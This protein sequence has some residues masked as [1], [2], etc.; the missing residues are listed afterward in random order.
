MLSKCERQPPNSSPNYGQNDT[1]EMWIRKQEPSWV[2]FVLGAVPLTPGSSLHYHQSH[3]GTLPRNSND[4]SASQHLVVFY[5]TESSW[6]QTES[7][8]ARSRT[9]HNH[10]VCRPTKCKCMQMYWQSWPGPQAFAKRLSLLQKVGE[11][12]LPGPQR[13]KEEAGGL[14]KQ[15][16][17]GDNG[18]FRKQ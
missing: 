5:G 6:I 16:R 18:T 14:R 4:Y 17:K 2:T 7:F 15:K 9:L 3:S 13:I 1:G 12:R 11:H 10:H 8:P